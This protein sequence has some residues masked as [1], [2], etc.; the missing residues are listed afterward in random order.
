M[1]TWLVVLVLLFF[2]IS[3]YLD[4]KYKA[5][6]SVFLTS[7]LFIVFVL[8]P[9]NLAFGIG[10]GIFAWFMKDVLSI[11]DLEF[12]MAD[13]K[14][15]IIIG[16]LIPTMNLFLIYIGIF[17]LFQFVYTIIWQVKIGNDGERPFIPLLTAVYL[18]LIMIGGVA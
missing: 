3:S 14:I 15:M 18:T 6:P 1:I 12:G 9:E 8:R 11:K 7:V 17:A 13:I 10:A 2:L 4:I 5:I 16:L